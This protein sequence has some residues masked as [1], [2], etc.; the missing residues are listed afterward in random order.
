MDS[1]HNLQHSRGS[2]ASA[3]PVI[4]NSEEDCKVENYIIVKTDLKRAGGAIGLYP[5]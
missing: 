3:L 2:N 4:I 5:S 1:T